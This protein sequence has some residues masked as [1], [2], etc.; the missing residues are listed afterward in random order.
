MSAELTQHFTDA[1]QW[2][3]PTYQKA[4][5]HFRRAWPG[6]YDAAPNVKGREGVP[7]VGC[8]IDRRA[9]EAFSK[10]HSENNRCAPMCFSCARVLPYDQYYDD[11]VSNEETSQ[12]PTT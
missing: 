4:V 9:H 7:T 6:V 1:E 8:C 11:G 5:K 3:D 2:L 10:R 12:Q